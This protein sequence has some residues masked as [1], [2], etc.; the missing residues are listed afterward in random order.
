MF[1]PQAKRVM[2][3]VVEEIQTRHFDQVYAWVEVGIGLAGNDIHAVARV[4][5]CLA[6]VLDIDALAAP[7]RMAAIAQQADAQRASSKGLGN[8][9]GGGI[10]LI[11]RA[12]ILLAISPCC[13]MFWHRVRGRKWLC[14]HAALLICPDP[15]KPDVLQPEILTLPALVELISSGR[16]LEDSGS[17]G[18]KVIAV[19]NNRYLKLLRVNSRLSTW[20]L[21]NPAKRFACNAQ[22]LKAKGIPTLTVEK[23]Y[24]VPHLKCWAVRYEGLEGDS[25]R[26]LLKQGELTQ[27]RLEQLVLF[28]KQLHDKGIYFRG[29]HPGNILLTPDGQLG[30]IDILDCYFRPYLFTFQ[31]QRN[32]KHFFRY[33]DAKPLESVIRA[34]YAQ[35]QR[36]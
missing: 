6:Q 4:Y 28:I 16:V 12:R 23:L 7:V 13:Q 26:Q 27:T 2:T 36:G 19:G 11:K 34:C 25:I 3:R 17:L 1:G 10:F 5:Q 21:L 20:G 8:I 29:L 31:R 9:H 14:Y 18:P 35:Y 30:L 15:A 33:A 32:F 24:R 22:R